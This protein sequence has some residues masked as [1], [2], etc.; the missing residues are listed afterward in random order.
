MRK[1]CRLS[2]QASLEGLS[3][4]SAS[5]QRPGR[6]SMFGCAARSPRAQVT[7]VIFNNGRSSVKKILLVLALAAAI[8]LIFAFDLYRYLSLDGLREIQDK[9]AAFRSQAPIQL[10]VY[11]LLTYI[12][13]AG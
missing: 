9:I 8:A 4:Q 11:F 13:A 3:A 2:S 10:A 5:L 6:G 12:V 7:I 1:C